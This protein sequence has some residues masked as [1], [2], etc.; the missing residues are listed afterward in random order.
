MRGFDHLK[1]FNIFFCLGTQQ[2]FP[3]WVNKEEGRVEGKC[4]GTQQLK[5]LKLL[6]LGKPFDHVGGRKGR[7]KLLPL[8]L[9][10]QSFYLEHSA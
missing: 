4:S 1:C 3:T 6:H 2:C 10:S 9:L 8:L 5:Y 7:T